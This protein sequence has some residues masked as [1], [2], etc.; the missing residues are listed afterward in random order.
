MKYF[1][2]NL[3]WL[4]KSNNLLQAEM[5]D[6]LGIEPSTWSNYERGKS[7][8]N[9][10]LFH[11][12]ANYFNITESDLL[13]TDLAHGHLNPKTLNR[14][15]VRLSVRLN[16]VKRQKTAANLEWQKANPPYQDEGLKTTHS[17]PKVVTIDQVGEENVLYVPVKARAGYLLGY[18]DPEYIEKLPAFRLPDHR[19][20]SYRIFEVE[21]L[22]MFPTLQDNDRVIARWV[23]LSEVRDDRIYV[24]VTNNYGIL[25][26]RILSRFKEGILV[27]KSDNENRS[28]YPNQV[29]KMN[30]VAECWY[31]VERW[32]RTLTNPGEIYRRITTMETDIA[33][34]K[35]RL[36]ATETGAEQK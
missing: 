17:V 14:E 4:R 30:D 11:S 26:K 23:Q 9:L 13:N 1:S 25:I 19:N 21:G 22:S 20:G 34:L 16:H 8:P 2:S 5:H 6:R 15:N 36:A 12:I 29:I 7:F 27:A 10:K 31:V 35:E 24:I 28:D 18:G 33:L 32:T 3:E